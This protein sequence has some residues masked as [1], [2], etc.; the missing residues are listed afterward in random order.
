LYVYTQR[1]NP[2]NKLALHGTPLS[3]IIGIIFGIGIFFAMI[4]GNVI[5]AA[6]GQVIPAFQVSQATIEQNKI[7]LS[8][9]TAEQV[10]YIILITAQ[11]IATEITFRGVLLKGLDDSLSKQHRV[12]KAVVITTLLYAGIFA[13]INLSVEDLIVNLFT[14]FLLCIA[15]Y[16]A[17]KSIVATMVAQ[18]IFSALYLLV[19]F[20]VLLI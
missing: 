8:A 15:F 5:E 2:D 18:G 1:L 11:N 13:A 19:L 7:I 3:V 10:G 16:A 4:G 6:I 14:G 17:K 12:V 20:G 9:T